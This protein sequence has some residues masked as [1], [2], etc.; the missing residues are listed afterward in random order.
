LAL[1]L[2]IS[3]VALRRSQQLMS[4][5]TSIIALGKLEGHTAALMKQ[6]EVG[7]TAAVDELA[8]GPALAAGG[9]GRIP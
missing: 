5:T 3:A 6:Y 9:L 2:P 4:L 7:A 1:A 8:E